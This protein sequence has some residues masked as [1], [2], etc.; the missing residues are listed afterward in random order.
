MGRFW[1]FK[2]FGIPKMQKPSPLRTPKM[3]FVV[4]FSKKKAY[5]KEANLRNQSMAVFITKIAINAFK[6]NKIF[7]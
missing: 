3:F 5:K 4:A 2:L 1:V 7:T 6:F